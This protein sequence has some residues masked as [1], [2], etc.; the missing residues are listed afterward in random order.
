[1]IRYIPSLALI[2]TL[3]VACGA[4]GAPTGG[5]AT[6]QL[7]AA[8]TQPAAP[9]QPPKPTTPPAAATRTQ[10]SKGDTGSPTGDLKGV[11]VIFKRSGGIAGVNETLTVYDDGRIAF[12]GRDHESTAQIAPEEL[13]A[14][15]Q[16]LASPEF[17]AL[18]SRYP[19]MGADLFIYS[20]TTPTGGKAQTVVT[21][22]GAKN[23]PILDQVLAEMGKLLEAQAK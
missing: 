14:L 6:T 22:D 9:T 23:P 7:P 11:L 16:L 15:R 10:P 3:L 12:A 13:S 5:S 1:M 19:A 20:I 18:D 4:S 2:A 8:T 17:A 21:M